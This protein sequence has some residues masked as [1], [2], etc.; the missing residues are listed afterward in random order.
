MKERMRYWMLAAILAIFCGVG[1]YIWCSGDNAPS[2]SSRKEVRIAIAWRA[3]ADNEFCTNIVEAFREA[4]VTVTVLPQVKAGYLD[5]SGDAVAATCLDAD[6]IGYLSEASGALVRSRGYDGSNAA[7]VLSGVDGV[8]F[9]GGEDIAP[10]L[11]ASPQDWHRIEAEIDYNAARD[12][13]DFLTMT[14]CLDYDIPLIG[15]CRGAQMLGVVS[16]ATIIQDIPTWF[17]QQGLSYNYEHRREK[18]EGETYRDYTPHDV[19][20][21]KGS[22]LARFFGTTTLTGC[23][24]WHHQALLS[25]KGTPLRVTATTTVSGIDMVEGI[26]HTDKRCAVGVQFHP[27]AAIVK[28]VGK[29]MNNANAR[30]FMTYEAAIPLFR[31]FIEVCKNGNNDDNN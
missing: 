4:G 14:Y 29:A 19:T 26:E 21:T 30:E 20:L 25:T 12:V 7:E 6:G 24:S 27:E 9:T 8:I 23:P 15:F 17:A 1:I 22:L 5:Y 28:H 3:D 31:A 10:T 13:S 18:A 11:L 16:G 2:D